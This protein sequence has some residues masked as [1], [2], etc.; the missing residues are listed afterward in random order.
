M[1]LI[2][3]KQLF[4]TSNGLYSLL[5]AIYLGFGLPMLTLIFEV[6]Q[7]GTLWC[8]MVGLGSGDSRD[9]AHLLGVIHSL[10]GGFGEYISVDSG[11]L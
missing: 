10:V 4:D 1:T 8:S 9:M 2:Q 11:P 6:N 7:L 3:T 5:P